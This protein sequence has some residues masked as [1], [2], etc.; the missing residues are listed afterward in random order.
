MLTI[1]HNSNCSKS[2]EALVRVEHYA[3]QHDLP[4]K[5]VNYLETP[6]NMTQLSSLQEL[7]GVGA[8]D[9][10]RANEEEYAALGLEQ[11]DDITL[12]KAIAATPKLLQRPIVV[13]GEKAII[14]R[15]PE[16]LG[17]LLPQE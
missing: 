8:H 14:A 17:R 15:P 5:V 12:L 9:L 6:L 4:V 7:L 1:Y 16:L 13:F 10:V 2:R 11:A 3:R